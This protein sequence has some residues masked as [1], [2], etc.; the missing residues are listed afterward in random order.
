MGNVGVVPMF[1]DYMLVY[2]GSSIKS[3]PSGFPIFLSAFLLAALRRA[4]HLPR[5][6]LGIV[7]QAATRKLTL[8]LDKPSVSIQYDLTTNQREDRAITTNQCRDRAIRALSLVVV[9]VST[10]VNPS[11][12]E[13]ESVT[14]PWS[15]GTL[16][17]E[18]LLLLSITC[19]TRR[20]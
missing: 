17:R 14:H 9:T 15:E 19:T 1:Y 7:Q 20:Y 2:Q 12:K 5:N 11:A 8:W 3:S 10:L 6:D 16:R 13:N 18:E 4:L